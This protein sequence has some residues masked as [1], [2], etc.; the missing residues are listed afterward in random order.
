MYGCDHQRRLMGPHVMTM[1]SSKKADGFPCNDYVLLYM[2]DTLVISKN[3]KQIL[4]GEIW[5]Y[6]ELKEELIGPPK[7]YLGGHAQK[8]TL[9]NAMSVWLFSS[10]QYVGTVVQNVEEYLMTDMS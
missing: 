2:D 1:Y 7:I 5:K 10:S 9:N 4:R 3:A 8:V 6:F